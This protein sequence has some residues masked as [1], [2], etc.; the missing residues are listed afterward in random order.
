LKKVHNE[1]SQ[2]LVTTVQN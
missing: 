1:D 2:I